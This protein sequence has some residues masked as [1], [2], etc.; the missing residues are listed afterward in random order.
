MTKCNI[1]ENYEI[2]NIF[3]RKH[4]KVW[5]SEAFFLVFLIKIF[6]HQTDLTNVTS[7]TDVTSVKKL[8]YHCYI[9]QGTTF[10]RY[11]LSSSSLVSLSLIVSSPWIF[12]FHIFLP[13]CVSS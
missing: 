4:C 8:L 13:I 5:V 3:V 2:I 12:L 6:I 10:F 11:T 7:V 9:F 1:R